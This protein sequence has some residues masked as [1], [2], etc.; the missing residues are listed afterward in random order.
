MQIEEQAAGR[1]KMDQ[2]KREKALPFQRGSRKRTFSL[3]GLLAGTL[4]ATSIAANAVPPST[5]LAA[6]TYRA[7]W[8]GG[9]SGWMSFP[10]AQDVGY[11][12]T[13]Y[14]EKQG[15]EAVL[16]HNFLSH[17]EPTPWFGMI[18]PL[19]FFAD[20]QSA[21]TLRYRLKLA[22]PMTQAELLLAGADGN[23]YTAPIPSEA[24]EHSVTIDGAALHLSGEVPFQAIVLRG[25][26]L[27]PPDDSR[28]EWLL[29][30]VVVRGE[31]EAQVPLSAPQLDAAID[32]S[33]VAGKPVFAGEDL[34]IVRTSAAG[35]AQIS[36]YDSKGAR[37]SEHGLAAGDASASLPLGANPAPGM[38]KAEVKQGAARTAFQ[39]LVLGK[40]PPHPRVLLSQS[41][42]DALNHDPRYAAVRAQIHAR[43]QA[44]AKKI[45][46]NAY[47]GTNI[48]LMP[49]G[50]G[51]GPAMPGELRP[52]IEMVQDYA[53][54]VAYNALDYR[55]NGNK[56]ALTAARKALATMATWE[57]WLP[58]RFKRHGFYTYYE[59]GVITQRTA[60]G[61]DLIANE[62]TA[63]EKKSAADAFWKQAIFPAVEEYFTYNRD[64]IAASNWMANSVG[65]AIAAAVATAGDTSSWDEREASALAKLEFAYEEL[66][67][68][69]F[70]GDGSEAEP[71][72]YE[73]FA[74]QGIS[75][76]ISSLRAL[77]IH[78]RGTERMM[79]AF[80]WP[81]Y[82]TVKP[83][84]Q[85]DTGDFNGHLTG[86]PGFA[87]GAEFSGIP[88]LRAFYDSGTH[89]D[90]TKSAHGGENGHMLEEQLN[91]IDV[92]CCSGPAPAF[93]P[94]PP[95]RVFPLRGSAVLRSGW[96]RDATVIS[97]RVGP[98][99]NHEHHDEGSF[100]VAAF[101][102]ALIGEAGY[103][104]YYIDPHYPDYFTQAAGHNTVL[105]DG[106][107]FSQM[108]FAPRYWAAFK[109]PH[110]ASQ[111]LSSYFDYLAADLT[112]AYDGKL[113][114]Y[115]RQYVFLK[116][117]ILIVH[118]EVR[119]PEK[120]VFTWLL[121]APPDAKLKHDGAAASIQAKDAHADLVAA[122][123]NAAWSVEDTPIP[124][125][126]FTD[127]DHQH[128]EPRKEFLLTSPSAAEAEFLVGMK[129]AAGSA[130]SEPGLQ[131]WSEE[132]GEGLRTAG[133]GSEGASVVFRTGAGDLVLDALRTDG[134]VLAQRGSGGNRWMAVG[135]QSVNEGGKI[136][137][138][139]ATPVDIAWERV[140]GTTKIA[141]RTTTTTALNIFCA[142]P[143]AS[144]R[145]DGKPGVLSY[146]DK[147]LTVRVFPGE[148]HVVIR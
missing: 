55:L 97:L 140:N 126:L 82:T 63:Q 135:A 9:F 65:G 110:F 17:G 92:V 128:I 113:Q 137:F 94:P 109:Y 141:V 145:M 59:V 44:L 35:P 32:G 22:C 122:G 56:N 29:E 52:Y 71:Y 5:G 148:H 88:E 34:K 50:K 61:Y 21:I 3:A 4:L 62:L 20:A 64:P 120:H 121:H 60:F 118:D 142:E 75:W 47:A 98:W 78:P 25:R 57:T 130:G 89:L 33:W 31:R 103:G 96:D 46:Y 42:V 101:G 6:W 134:S 93:T 15:N 90:L 27:H 115:E 139:S 83:G 105:I 30:A 74:M 19:S 144:V 43:A 100:Q 111:L 51:I 14:V 143:P 133:S 117:D 69:L 2:E 41:H 68:G 95:S 36:L 11:D 87:W 147:M 18:R 39:F 26:L 79:Q 73:N 37:V 48:E 12:P 112:P 49:S 104:S 116:P 45:T 28:S 136:I 66:L 106:N 67:Q 58:P 138:R 84:L 146:Q 91:A 107:P 85:L 76:G 77:G 38:W 10:L 108:A 13:L 119:A 53:D 127:L 99:F 102:N 114:S 54:A 123:S 70:P 86:L 24:G 80:W 132:A 1:T 16:R 23:R 81:Y 40:I 131:S 8:E 72:G 125:T 7:D 129:F 124:V